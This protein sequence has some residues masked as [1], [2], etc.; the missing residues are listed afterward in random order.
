MQTKI[1][2]HPS[3]C[4]HYE[5]TLWKWSC[6]SLI[7]KRLSSQIPVN[8]GRWA[9]ES[10]PRHSNRAQWS[11]VG[12]H[13]KASFTPSNGGFIIIEIKPMRSSSNADTTVISKLRCICEKMRCECLEA[14]STVKCTGKAPSARL[15]TTT[16]S[17]SVFLICL[18][19]LCFS[20]MRDT[21]KTS[22]GCPNPRHSEIS[23]CSCYF[24]F[25]SFA[26]VF[27]VAATLLD[28]L[29]KPEA[30]TLPRWN[31]LP[32]LTPLSVFVSVTRSV[33]LLTSLSPQFVA[34]SG[35]VNR[36][37]QCD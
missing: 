4:V 1:L 18:F 5:A 3:R 30:K 32:A 20:L 24:V 6:F 26:Q 34:L 25:I 19:S 27:H 11:R 7:F 8:N 12:K 23:L 33:S 13:R 29:S 14:V 9:D 21:W 28:Q 36:A 15:L 22:P 16:C 17:R 37:C 2:P 35:R 10:S 31:Q